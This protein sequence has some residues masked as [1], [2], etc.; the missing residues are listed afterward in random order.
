VLECLLADYS[1]DNLAVERDEQPL[2][3]GLE[4]LKTNW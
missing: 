1:A 2:H 3:D 4:Q